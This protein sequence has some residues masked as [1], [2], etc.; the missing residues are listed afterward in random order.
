MTR[1]LLR[2]VA[3]PGRRLAASFGRLSGEVCGNARIHSAAR[4][5]VRCDLW[6]LA[7]L[8]L[9]DG[10]ASVVGARVDLGTILEQQ[11]DEISPAEQRG[12]VKRCEA[13]GLACVAMRKRLRPRSL[14]LAPFPRSTSTTGTLP[15]KAAKCRGVQPDACRVPASFGSTFSIEF[16]C[17]AVPTAQA[18][19][20]S[21]FGS[22]AS[23]AFTRSF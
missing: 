13:A 12:F 14:T 20:K 9:G 3:H 17:A 10:V 16:T 15:P 2:E 11:I 18:S 22:W 19:K 5:Q 23:T 6:M 8:R 21:S 7:A 1:P 4:A